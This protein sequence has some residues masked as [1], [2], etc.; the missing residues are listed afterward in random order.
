M[1]FLPLLSLGKMKGVMNVNHASKEPPPS[2][3][4]WVS[5]TS[6]PLLQEQHQLPACS[7]GTRAQAKQAAGPQSFYHSRQ[8]VDLDNCL[9]CLSLRQSLFWT[10][11]NGSG[12]GLDIP[13]T[14]NML[15]PPHRATRES[16]ILRKLAYPDRCKGLLGQSATDLTRTN[17]EHSP[18]CH[19]DTG[20]DLKL[21]L[22]AF[23]IY[24]K[25]LNYAVYL[26]RKSS[27]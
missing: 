5:D 17:C 3:Q 18:H 14:P 16:S 10:K 1:D 26:S 2:Q 12:T 7:A 24:C 11:G 13:Q 25:I 9:F 6:C 20:F 27:T 21:R 19:L 15:W 8:S 22:E 23:C 4:S